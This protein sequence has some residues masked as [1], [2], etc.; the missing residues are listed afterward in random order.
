MR[1]FSNGGSRVA[2]F[3]DIMDP[4]DEIL[5]VNT[6]LQEMDD[7]RC[8]KTHPALSRTFENLVQYSSSVVAQFMQ[9]G[10]ISVPDEDYAFIASQVERTQK[11]RDI[12]CKIL[13]ETGKV[14]FR[15]PPDVF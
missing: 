7:N 1:Y 10:G 11:T 2:S 12:V 4:E 6:F 8:L 9:C 13:C 14:R 5:F 15:V 3:A